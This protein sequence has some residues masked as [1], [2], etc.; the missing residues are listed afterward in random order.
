MMVAITDP[1]KGDTIL[2][3]AC[4][5]A[6]FLISSYKHVLKANTDEN[7]NC[8]LSADDRRYINNG[9]SGYDIS[10]DMVRL[11]RVNMY[12]HRFARPQIYEYDTLSSLDR[13][14]EQFDVIMANPPF[15]TPKGGINPHNRYRVQAKRAEVL[16]VDYIAEHLNPNGRAAII[17]P[18]GIV[19]Q[20]TANAYKQLRKY[21][22]DDNLLYAVVS[23]PAGV[24]NPYSGVKT[25]I[26]FIDK[27]LA[28]NTDKILFIK[29]TNYGYDLGAQ[30]REIKNNDIPKIIEL[31]HGYKESLVV[32]EEYELTDT[33]QGYANLA[34]KIAVASQDY[35]LVGDRY[36]TMDNSKST[37]SMVKIGDAFV[38]SSG[39]TP[40]STVREYYLNG[41][42]PWLKSG[43][44]VNGFI[45]NTEEMI[46]EQGLKNSSA[47]L[48]PINTVVIAMYGAT[49]GQVGVLKIQST[50]NQAIC[51]ILPND[52]V[53]P[54]Y[55]YYL[56]I[57]KREH[58]VSLS[59]GGAQPNISQTIIKNM[60][61]PL[62]PLEFQ[63]QIVSVINHYQKI[64]NGAREIVDNYSPAVKIDPNWQMVKVE[65]VLEFVSGVTLSVGEC[66]SE[67]G[68]PIIT[69]ADVSEQGHLKLDNI[70][71]V[72]TEKN[73]NKPQK[74][75]L[76]FNWRNGSKHLVGK[77]ALF[78]LDGEYLFASFLLGLRPDTD[79]ILSKFLWILLNQYRVEGKYMQFMRQNVNGLFN[80]EELKDVLIPLPPLE[81]QKQ[82]VAQIDEELQIVEQ[83]KRLINIFE[84]K[85]TNKID[86]IWGK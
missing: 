66:E 53:K 63:D 13:W 1:K 61:I 64:I 83:N 74:G 86:E 42:I 85:I 33:E 18:E 84:Q 58:L 77:T 8:T 23:M 27:A 3:P 19:F 75:D 48:F 79:I 70:R 65:D 44:V 4:G 69:I 59:T 45:Y 2:D 67:D 5:T 50:T 9:Y 47:K 46:T 20:Q 56:L 12:L 81:V 10:P 52:K 76:L 49:V 78:D 55:L 26:L 68:V 22:V 73:V 57:S 24:F 41:S 38:T 39:G 30:R 6:G 51:G 36:K 29:M 32:G 17:V 62:P 60:Q 82:L 35:I 11:S 43:E 40:K 28:K 54:E 7:G 71:K 31:M 25:S 34:N 15:M 72:K 80:R 14:D 21:L 37:Y 16:F